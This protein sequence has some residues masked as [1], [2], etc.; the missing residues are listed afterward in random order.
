[1]PTAPRWPRPHTRFLRPC[2]AYALSRLVR[3][4]HVGSL[5][6][7]ARSLSDICFARSPL[8][9]EQR[10]DITH[11]TSSTP[12]AATSLPSPWLRRRP[13]APKGLAVPRVARAGLGFVGEQALERSGCKQGLPRR[14]HPAMSIRRRP[15][16]RAQDRF[17]SRSAPPS[18]EG[19]SPRL[20]PRGGL[21]VPFP[22][23]VFRPAPAN[24]TLT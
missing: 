22:Q 24:G 12:S 18:A 2:P 17:S 11:C 13:R 3:I 19:K 15:P 8:G 7:A 10:S 5:G 9:T 1:M 23:L 6:R 14:S 20:S 4:S 21:I 16:E